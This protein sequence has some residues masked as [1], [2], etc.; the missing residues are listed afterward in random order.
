VQIDTN[1][2]EIGD[3]AKDTITGFEGTVIGITQWTTG[4]ARA[5]LQARVNKDGKVPDSVGFDV[6]TLELVKAGP[7][8]DV[9]R[10]KGG[11]RDEPTRISDP[12]R[13]R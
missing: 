4:C 7:R 1:G 10:S 5:S 3:V 8:H 2:I 12:D 9:D 13:G 11:P 6:L